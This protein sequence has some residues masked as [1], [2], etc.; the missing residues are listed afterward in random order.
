M[1]RRSW[2]QSRQLTFSYPR[3]L[4][5]AYFFE[6]FFAH[7]QR[8]NCK[9]ASMIPG[10][11]PSG[12]PRAVHYSPLQG[13]DKVIIQHFGGKCIICLIYSYCTHS[14]LQPISCIHTTDSCICHLF[15]NHTIRNCIRHSDVCIHNCMTR[16]RA[17]EPERDRGTGMQMRSHQTGIQ[18]RKQSPI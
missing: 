8:A 18:P 10:L 6:V 12:S 1:T 15:C 4:N 5:R 14:H 3:S 13:S 7:F 9:D 2:P 17:P 11:R 16:L